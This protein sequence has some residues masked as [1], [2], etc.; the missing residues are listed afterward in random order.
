[1]QIPGL[2]RSGWRFRW[3]WDLA[4][5]GVQ[6]VTRLLAPRLF[7]IGVV[8]IDVLI[9]S[10]FAALMAAGSAASITFAD[11]VME[12][13]LG[14]YVIALSTAILPLLSRL[15]VERRI[16]ELKVT[17]NFAIRIVLFVSL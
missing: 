1:I 12:L 11:R 2:I 6:R 15:A 9:G 3:I 13:V 14:G 4:D 7:A 17:L 16:D 5:P 8:H 10:Q